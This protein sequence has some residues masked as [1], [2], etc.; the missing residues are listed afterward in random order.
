MEVKPALA[1]SERLE[2]TTTEMIDDVFTIT[3]VSTQESPCC[4]LCNTKTSRMH[5]HYTRWVADLPCGGQPVRL[6]VL[7]RQYFVR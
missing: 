4:S 3:A 1:L 6:Q 5:S 7:V 2:V